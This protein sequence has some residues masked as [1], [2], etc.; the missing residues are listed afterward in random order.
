MVFCEIISAEKSISTNFEG[1]VSFIL[2]LLHHYF[3]HWSILILS[4]DIG[5]SRNVSI[6]KIGDNS[7]CPAQEISQDSRDFYQVRPSEICSLAI[8]KYFHPC[9]LVVL[10]YFHS[11]H[12]IFSK[13]VILHSWSRQLSFDFSYQY[14]SVFIITFFYYITTYLYTYLSSFLY[15]S[16][17]FLILIMHYSVVD[18]PSISHFPCVV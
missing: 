8:Y 3:T 1:C 17:L 15:A 5:A 7:F 4:I 10:I 18:P 6:I 13:M 2:S 16:N 11:N 14:M 12:R 9:M